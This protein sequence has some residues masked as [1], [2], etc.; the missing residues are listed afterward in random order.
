MLFN[1]A[2][3]FIFAPIVILF[4]FVFPKRFQT[5]WLFVV[6]LYFYAI[7]RVPFLLLLIF[8]F[9]VTKLA[10]DAM[11]RTDKR[12][13]KIFWLNVSI[14]SNLGLL[15]VFKYLDFS[16]SAWNSLFGLKE[17][18]P[19]FVS[20]LGIILPMGISFFTLQAVSYA[21]DVF[22][23]VVQPAK[24]I[25][26]FGL[27]I[28][29]FPQLV[30]GPI[31]RA[32][33][34]L[35]QF[36]EPKEFQ[37]EN[38]VKGLKQLF[39]G[40]F[41]KTFI[42]DPVSYA[43]DPVFADPSSY[44]GAAIWV[45]GILF[46]VQVYCDFSGY[47]DIAIGTA[48][49]LGFH[50]PKNF[51]RPFLSGTLGELWRR[52]HISFSSWL[53]EYVYIFL[54]GSKRGEITTYINLFITTFVS[55]IWHGADWTYIIWGAVHAAVMVVER[56]AFKFKAIKN[57]WDSVP[58]AIQPIYP[59]FVFIVTI[60]FFRARPTP[61]YPN[62]VDVSFLMLGRAFT[63][64]E[65]LMLDL[66]ISLIL[67]I[68]FLFFVDIVQNNKEDYFDFITERPLFLYTICSV[69]Y[70]TAFLIYSVTVS[71]PFLYFQF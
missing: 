39:W 57:A 20:S 41:K 40:V 32:T 5:L 21:V 54:G 33:D 59:F 67:V 64:P 49:I 47:S 3:Y 70:I 26:H 4:Y 69:M 66:P 46:G 37:K 42:A 11:E 22:R 65:G 51:D 43:I 7:F 63:L 45:S 60:F 9:V 36:L 62:A 30:A 25:F 10:V 34:V 61:A 31:L 8:S 23:G 68:G 1:S 56:F 71:S 55:G 18:D 28:S 17:C 13:S 12:G 48:R 19:G 44:S 27:F 58:R 14:W 24:S 52:W 38:L 50:I 53:R 2:H 6:S 29:F 16:I 35:S 15:F